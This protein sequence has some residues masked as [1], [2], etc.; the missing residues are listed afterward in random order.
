AA[1]AEAAWPPA[2]GE[3]SRAR[4]VVAGD[5]TLWVDGD[6]FAQVLVNLF[7]NAVE[8]LGGRP[9]TVRVWAEA[10]GTGTAVVVS[11]D[12]PGIPPEIQDRL[13][14]AF[15]ST[16]P[17]GNGL[18]LLI[19]RHLVEA[20]GGRLSLSSAPGQ[21]TTVRIELPAPPRGG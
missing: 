18:G 1:L 20:H 5:A 13:F 15:V 4:L 2:A 16:K 8:A 7:R 3:G 21:G 12:G 14:S 6:R 11:D 10:A 9:G 17:H 19:V